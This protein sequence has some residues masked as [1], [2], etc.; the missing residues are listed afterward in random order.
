MMGQQMSSSLRGVQS[1]IREHA[2]SAYCTHCQA[3]Q[4]NSCIVKACSISDVRNA[5][6]VVSDI[7][8]FFNYSP[9]RQHFL[10]AVISHHAEGSKKK[11]SNLKDLCKKGGL[12]V[13]IHFQLFL[14]YT[15]SYFLHLKVLL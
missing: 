14:S 15:S 4:L 9:K 7:A 11:R 1:C 13:S 6:G 5:S 12:N 10:E 3:H 2:P 8:N